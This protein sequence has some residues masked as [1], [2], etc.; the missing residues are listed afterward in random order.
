MPRDH[1]RYAI[2]GG[3]LFVYG[4]LMRQQSAHSK[5]EGATFLG[6]A[7]TAPGHFLVPVKSLGPDAYSLARGGLGAVEG[8]VYQVSLDKLQEL[9]TWEADYHR[10]YVLLDD[11]K[12]VDTYYH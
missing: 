6:V 10:G 2:T 11:G 1:I 7:R 3:L 12:V 4:T 8:E 9:D 5:M